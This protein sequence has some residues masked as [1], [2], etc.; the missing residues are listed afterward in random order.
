[1]ALRNSLG[2]LLAY[3]AI[4]ALLIGLQYAVAQWLLR[5]KG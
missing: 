2:I 3:G 1:M 4:A 5:E